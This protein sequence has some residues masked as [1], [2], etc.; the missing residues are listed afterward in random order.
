MSH[1]VVLEWT[2]MPADY[3]EE[4]IQ[5]VRDQYEMTI[6]NGKVEAR[7]K[8]EYYD[9]TPKKCVMKLH[10]AL[11]DRF[12]S[13]QFLT[14]RPYELIRGAMHRLH[15]DDS[16]D[17]VIS[18]EDRVIISESPDYTVGDKNG[19]VTSD[20]R[21]E[22]IDKKKKWNDLVEKHISNPVV[23]ATLTSY[24]AAVRDPDNELVHLYEIRDALAKEFKGENAACQALQVSKA[25]WKRLGI[26]ANTEPLRQ[27]RHRGQ[28][29]GALRDA[30]EDELRKAHRITRDLIQSYLEYLDSSS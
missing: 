26:L 12:L 28:H 23:K 8:P 25:R 5:I 30:T 9:P 4:P 2:F 6:D 7:I 14:R 19:N 18:V 15:S 29:S 3:F 10:D 13:A 27:G 16:K 11:S 21:K 20:S 24:D 22:R 17:I 1:I